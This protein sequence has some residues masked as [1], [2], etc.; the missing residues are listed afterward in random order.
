MK[1]YAPAALAAIL[2]VGGGW[3]ISGQ[4]SQPSPSLSEFAVPGAAMAQSAD[5]A[6]PVEIV[7]MSI[8]DADAPVEV[9]EY[10]S[11]TCPFCADFHTGTVYEN[12]KET[13][14]DT[15]L[16]HWTY[17][18]VYFDA[19]GVWASLIARCTGPERFFGIVDLIY[20]QQ[21]AWRNAGS[22][23]AIATELRRL[24]RVAGMPGDEVEACLNDRDK[25]SALVEW[26]Q[27]NAAEHG[28]RSTPSFVIDGETYQNMS[29]AEF[30]EII[31]AR[32]DR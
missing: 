3:W 20:E 7:E 32:L 19:P 8:G 12:L 28:I 21:D 26:Y 31:D 16:V 25:L 15:G 13:Y 11:F 9:I 22:N 4:G 29:F 17:R 14:V 10:S 6:Q 18:E 5:A 2:A 30:A 23:A 27:A 1:W 24:A